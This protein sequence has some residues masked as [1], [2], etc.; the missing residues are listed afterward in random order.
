M[1]KLRNPLTG[2]DRKPISRFGTGSLSS[3]WKLSEE[4]ILAAHGKYE[5]SA[6]AGVSFADVVSN[7]VYVRISL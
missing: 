4:F 5:P 1:R 6:G 3:T 7:F 2:Q